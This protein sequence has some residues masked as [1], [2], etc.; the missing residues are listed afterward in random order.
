MFLKNNGMKQRVGMCFRAER[1]S[2]STDGYEQ[3]VQVDKLQTM[4][5]VNGTLTDSSKHQTF[6]TSAVSRS[7]GKDF[8]CLERRVTVET[9]ANPRWRPE[10]QAEAFAGQ[11]NGCLT[12]LWQLASM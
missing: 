12:K 8:Q 1:R 9:R 6:T 4:E 5:S 3:Q 7:R 11:R 10:A 2:N